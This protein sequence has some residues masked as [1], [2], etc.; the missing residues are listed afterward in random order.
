MKLLRYFCALILGLIAWT[1]TASAE[2]KFRD[3]LKSAIGDVAGL[4]ETDV[5]KG[6]PRGE[7]RS[8]DA[9]LQDLLKVFEHE[10]RGHGHMHK[11]MH[12]HHHH[13]AHHDK[14]GQG[15]FKNGMTM[16][17]NQKTATPQAVGELAGK[18]AN[19][20][21]AAKQGPSKGVVPAST[22]NAASTQTPA[23]VKN[24]GSGTGQLAQVKH[25]SGQHAKH[26]DHD[27]HHHADWW[28]DA[29]HHK[30]A[31]SLVG[32]KAAHKHDGAHPVQLPGHL[33]GANASQKQDQAKHQPVAAKTQPTQQ[34]GAKTA[35]NNPTTAHRPGNTNL[36]A[37]TAQ[38]RITP[39]NLVGNRTGAKQTARITTPNRSVP[40]SHAGAKHA[41]SNVNAGRKK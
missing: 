14:Q 29:D 16:N 5:N 10:K 17:G 13:H 41:P 38:P 35:T 15:S 2:S 8:L 24:T 1:Q 12:H 25:E 26:K 18:Q 32:S 39:V 34:L 31:G 20:V 3:G 11:G 22:R 33:I 27:H 6:A 21:G 40:A 23:T 9:A 4:I 7:I 36:T 19:A 37:K 30:H 28:K